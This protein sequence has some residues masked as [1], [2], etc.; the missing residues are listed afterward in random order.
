M[1]DRKF[2]RRGLVLVFIILFLDVIG[3]AIIM[4]VMPAYLEQLTGGTVSQAAVYGG[5]L[6][7]VYAAM[8][9]L[10]APLVGNLSDRFGRRPILLASVLTFAIDNLIC[11]V[12]ISYWMLFVG[13]ML[14]GISGASFATCSAYIADISDDRNR[15]RNFGLIG[16]AFGSGFVLGPSSEDC[17]A[18]SDLAC[19]STA[20]PGFR[21][22]IFSSPVSCCRKRYSMRI[23]GAS[24]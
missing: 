16:M 21:S 6:L 23:A 18:N 7:L 1:I 2:V 13:R 8:Q 5:W 14:A 22:Q 20:R 11:A 19:L 3:I 4:P 15:A 9:F 17:W 10:C 24:S 12:A